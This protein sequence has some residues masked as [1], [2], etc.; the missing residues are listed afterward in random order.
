MVSAAH[1][2]R[3]LKNQESA[4]S[5]LGK[6]QE[7]PDP[8]TALSC[9]YGAIHFL[10]DL[11]LHIQ[12]KAALYMQSVVPLMSA[13]PLPELVRVRIRKSSKSYLTALD[14]LKLVS[15]LSIS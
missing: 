6:T 8:N 1:D 9:C 2:S 11:G 13:E 15:L 10:Y 14:S 12:T 5:R 4:D 3:S 7:G